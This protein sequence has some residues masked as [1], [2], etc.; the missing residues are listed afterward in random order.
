MKNQPPGT[1]YYV[2]Q[3]QEN[4]D[5]GMRSLNSLIHIENKKETSA[6]LRIDGLVHRSHG[7]DCYDRLYDG[8]HPNEDL[9]N[10][11]TDYMSKTIG[12][13]MEHFS[14]N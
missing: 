6:K 10:K 8:C 14:E 9:V 4:L 1:P 13:L 3:H 7:K 11:I 2:D 12:S 5:A